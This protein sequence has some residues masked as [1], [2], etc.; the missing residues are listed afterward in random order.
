MTSRASAKKPDELEDLIETPRVPSPPPHTTPA[1]RGVHVPSFASFQPRDLRFTSSHPVAHVAWSCDGR[2]L[3]SVGIDKSVRVWVPEKSLE[4]RSA[5]Q[6]NVGGHDYDA[7]VDYVV[8]NP[9]HPELFCS[10]SQRDR[11]IIFWDARQS[12]AVQSYTHHHPPSQINYAPDGKT[13]CFV[14]T[15]NQLYFMEYGKAEG[16]A[17]PQWNPMKRE[18]VT[19]S[20]AMFNHTG[21]GLALSY[22]RS[23]TLMILDYPSLSISEQPAAHVGGC[24]AGCARPSYLASGGNDSIVN[25]FDMSEWIC[26]NTI[27]ACDHSINALSF[28]HDG[29]YMA[30]ANQGSYISICAVETGLPIHRVPTIGPAPA[31]TWHP[32]KYVF[33]HCGQQN[34]EGAPQVA[35]LS[36]FGPGM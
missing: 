15:S 6:Y 9:T 18:P 21:D 36:L 2:R 30:I 11:K 19:A 26:I 33:A 23:N 17:K 22:I 10:S 13:I 27:T 35:F 34:R 20:T 25:I 29:E 12:R 5:V 4:P 28:S 1:A 14:T 16:E 8:W 31:V 3:A 24:L 7:T 32:S